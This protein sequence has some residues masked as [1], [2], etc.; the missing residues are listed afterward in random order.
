V[1]EPGG[2]GLSP[3]RVAAAISALVDA[4]TLPDA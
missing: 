3:S 1:A 2:G 4:G